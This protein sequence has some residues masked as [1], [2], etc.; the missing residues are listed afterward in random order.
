MSEKTWFVVRKYS[1]KIE[2]A[3]VTRSTDK[4]VFVMNG[5]H[6]SREAIDSEWQKWFPS[7][8]EAKA[9]LLRRE[10]SGLESCIK[11]AETLRR[12]I[13]S[14]KSMQEPAA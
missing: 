13:E 14:I 6:E 10:E 9:F 5:K 4:S 7:F 11:R 3:I 2:S 12:S 8:A 1:D